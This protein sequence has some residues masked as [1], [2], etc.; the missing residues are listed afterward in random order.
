MKK[1]DSVYR[2]AFKIILIVF[3]MGIIEFALFTV[4]LSLR[5]DI[6]LGTLY[7][8]SFVGFNLLFLAHSVKKAAE[9]SENG[10]KAYMASTYT[11]RMLFTAAAVIIAA[12][13]S[14]IHFW[15][16]IIPL[17]FQRIAVT[18]VPFINKRSEKS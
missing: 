12:N 9:K 14:Y 13:I 10:A 17:F 6:L 4:F 1:I 16:A 8:C 18:I 7:G 5:I 2:E 3:L 15:A 11:V